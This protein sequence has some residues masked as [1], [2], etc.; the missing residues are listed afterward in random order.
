L[1]API[2]DAAV[3][4]VREFWPVLMGAAILSVASAWVVIK[5]DRDG[6]A[7]QPERY[8]RFINGTRGV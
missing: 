3:R 7:V 5:L 2:G 1:N 4:A 8:E 6:A